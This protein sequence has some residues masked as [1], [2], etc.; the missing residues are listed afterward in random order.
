MHQILLMKN[1][2]KQNV[3]Q[4]IGS[5]AWSSNIDALG[6]ELSF[7]YAYNDS[8]FFKK[9]DLI[10]VGDQIALFNEGKF[11]NYYVVITDS[12]NGRFGKSFTCFDRSWYLNKNETVIQFKKAAASQAIA[13]L[14][15]KFGVKHQIASMPTLIT[16]IY[17]EE[18]VSDIM[19]D[20]LEQVYQETKQRYRVE[21]NKGILTIQKMSD[22]V[23]N[24][25]SRL[26]D[27]TYAFPVT[28]T[29]SN[30]S[31]ERSIEEMKNKVIVV[32]EDEKSTKV[33]AE[34]S[35]PKSISKYGQLTDVVTVEK[36][37]ASQARNIAANTLSE[38]N[39]MGETISCEM[40]GH[41]EIRAGRILNMNEPVTGIVGKY[42]IKSA[43]H[44][45]NNGI[46]KVSV[47][48]EAV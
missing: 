42:L 36:K 44:T 3:T 2:K 28:D 11:L 39:K 16:K 26:S 27:N 41:D 23:I 19:A 12:M 31:R 8:Q 30:P 9:W 33:F 35:D 25:I 20:I 7:N 14:L 18:L 5:L 4:L 48:L 37:N 46:H 10:E 47:E 13:K 21:M 32:S 38:M 24:P 43:S 17:K 45:V 22:L 29:I 1:G 6:E 15:D 34:A 40:I